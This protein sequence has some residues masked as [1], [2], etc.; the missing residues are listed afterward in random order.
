M[1][2]PSARVERDVNLAVIRVEHSLAQ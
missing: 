1:T 2:A